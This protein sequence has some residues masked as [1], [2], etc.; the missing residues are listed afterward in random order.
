MLL[1][2]RACSDYTHSLD[3]LH[4]RV[5]QGRSMRHPGAVPLLHPALW[6]G[7]P[8]CFRFAMPPAPIFRRLSAVSLRDVLGPIRKAVR[9]RRGA[10][11]YENKRIGGFDD[12][13]TRSVSEE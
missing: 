12:I 6:S 4:I 5:P 1:A 2:H 7:F 3:L 13:V 9:R 8:C 10:E 11:W